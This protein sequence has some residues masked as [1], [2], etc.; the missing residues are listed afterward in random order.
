MHRL[1]E[2]PWQWGTI[3]TSG[4]KHYCF[5]SS[6]WRW[7][8]QDR[9]FA[10]RRDRTSAL[11]HRK[12][13]STVVC[14]KEILSRRLEKNHSRHRPALGD[15]RRQL[16]FEKKVNT[17]NRFEKYSH[18]TSFPLEMIRPS[19]CKTQQRANLINSL[20]NSRHDTSARE[21]LPKLKQRPNK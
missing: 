19:V 3:R 4:A 8:N 20:Q 10:L 18:L 13:F 9:A 14:L 7:I 17:H 2:L 16:A 11:P 1:N 12:R 15:N 5:R 6:R 21:F